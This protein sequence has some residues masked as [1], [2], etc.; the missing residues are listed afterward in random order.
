MQS[1]SYWFSWPLDRECLRAAFVLDDTTEELAN[2]AGNL[3]LSNLLL[4]LLGQIQRTRVIVRRM[5]PILDWLRQPSAKID[6]HSSYYEPTSLQ[7]GDL[8]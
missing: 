6:A 8:L 2:L 5:D 1:R 4:Y 7:V 3:F